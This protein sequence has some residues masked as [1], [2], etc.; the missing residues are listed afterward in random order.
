MFVSTESC[1]INKIDPHT[2]DTKEKVTTIMTLHSGA[3]MLTQS[4][5]IPIKMFLNEKFPKHLHGFFH[6]VLVVICR[7]PQ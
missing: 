3:I 4:Y 2:L 7:R 5:G 1:Y 6:H